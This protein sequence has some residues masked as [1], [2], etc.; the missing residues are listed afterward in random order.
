MILIVSCI[1]LEGLCLFTVVGGD[2]S[3]IK[4]GDCLVAFSRNTIFSL[5]A[6]IEQHKRSH[7]AVVYGGLPSGKRECNSVE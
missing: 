2:F 5:K 3:K 1:T 6:R 4:P 7:C